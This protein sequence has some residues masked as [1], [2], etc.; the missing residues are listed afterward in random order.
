MIRPLISALALLSAACTVSAGVVKVDLNVGDIKPGEKI[1]ISLEKLI[2]D[3][4]YKLSCVLT[5][6]HVSGKPYNVVQVT[7]STNSSKVTVNADET[8]PGSH[9]Y[10]LPTNKNSYVT[11]GITKDIGDIT[12][13]NVDDA[14]TVLLSSCHAVGRT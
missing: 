8:S 11:G 6:N 3:H 14:D 9:L 10:N 7:T 13:M 1:V 5:S 12:I 2:P 4:V